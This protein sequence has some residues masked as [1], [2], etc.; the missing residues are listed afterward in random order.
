MDTQMKALV[1]NCSVLAASIILADWR[2]LGYGARVEVV[3]WPAAMVSSLPPPQ[4]RDLSRYSARNVPVTAAYD[5]AGQITGP[6]RTAF[7]L[8]T[9]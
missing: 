7:Y 9:V 5:A 1:I 3:S 2:N 4:R 8:T 6:S